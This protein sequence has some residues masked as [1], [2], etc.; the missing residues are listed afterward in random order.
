MKVPQVLALFLFFFSFKLFGKLPSNNSWR[1]PLAACGVMA[2]F[3]LLPSV[4][5]QSRPLYLAWHSRMSTRRLCS[6]RAFKDRWPILLSVCW[7]NYSWRDVQRMA[8]C[9]LLFCFKLTPIYSFITYHCLSFIL[10]YQFEGDNK[11]SISHCCSKRE[12]LDSRHM[13]TLR[14]GGGGVMQI[15]WPLI[16]KDPVPPRS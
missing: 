10:F 5:R 4:C 13:N 9:K 2:A 3:C 6:L 1:L 14:G 11:Q 16:I 7:P 8:E 12:W 15:N